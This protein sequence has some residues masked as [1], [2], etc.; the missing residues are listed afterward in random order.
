ML[1]CT[2]CWCRCRV[3][4]GVQSKAGVFIIWDRLFGTYVAEEV[5]KDYYGKLSMVQAERSAGRVVECFT[6]AAQRNASSKW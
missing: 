5:R 1:T 4:A 2:W 3:D 6:N